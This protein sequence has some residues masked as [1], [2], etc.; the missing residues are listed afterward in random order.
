M[1]AAGQ[2]GDGIRLHNTPPTSLPT[3]SLPWNR[4]MR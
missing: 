1:L 2:Q 4:T 3:N